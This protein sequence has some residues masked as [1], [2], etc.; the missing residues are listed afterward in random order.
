MKIGPGGPAAPLPAAVRERNI[1]FL[2]GAIAMRGAGCTWNDI[3]DRDFDAKV[4]RTALRPLPAPG[5]RIIR[6]TWATSRRMP[7]LIL[8]KRPY[9]PA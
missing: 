5:A 8:P 9:S 3:T 1:L 6:G 2:T 7:R 4:E